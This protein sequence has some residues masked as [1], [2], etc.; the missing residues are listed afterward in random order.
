MA[1]RFSDGDVPMIEVTS[2]AT[3]LMEDFFKDKRRQPVRLFVKLGACGIRSFGVSM[4]APTA[5]DKV[6]EV[7]GFEYVINKRLLKKVAPIKIDADL[8]GFRISGSGVY[9]PG[10]CGTCGYMC[11]AQGGGQ[12]TG[13]CLNC[14]LPCSHGRRVRAR[15]KLKK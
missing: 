2:R 13:D 11:G 3:E 7:D 10:G 4:E 15:R 14:Q 6:F 12:C 1:N 5:A 9:P 8:V